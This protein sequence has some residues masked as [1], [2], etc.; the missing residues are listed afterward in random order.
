MTS[1]GKL[2]NTDNVTKRRLVGKKA[3]CIQVAKATF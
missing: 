1:M 2:W 3:I